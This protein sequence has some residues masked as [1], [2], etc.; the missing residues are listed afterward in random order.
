M[1]RNGPGIGPFGYPKRSENSYD[2]E[3]LVEFLINLFYALAANLY[4]G[5][6]DGSSGGGQQ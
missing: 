6:S 5:S 2:S 4:L 3:A 1:P